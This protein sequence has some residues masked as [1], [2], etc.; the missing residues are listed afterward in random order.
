MGP[1]SWAASLPG[2]IRALV[3]APA[4]P[5]SVRLV[6]V[7]V[8]ACPFYS[9]WCGGG[10][11]LNEIGQQNS[12]AYWIAPGLSGLVRSAGLHCISIDRLEM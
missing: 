4:P 11:V 1:L 9:R 2:S 7:S 3:S 10:T 5:I 12:G 8:I 6:Q